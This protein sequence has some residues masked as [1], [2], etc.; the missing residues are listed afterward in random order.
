M[1]QWS[2]SN[3]KLVT[4]RESISQK[5]IT[6]LD[7]LQ[8]TSTP[9]NSKEEI[10]CLLLRRLRRRINRPFS[11]PLQI[12]MSQTL[13]TRVISRAINLRRQKKRSKQKRLQ[14]ILNNNAKTT[15]LQSPL[16]HL[17]TQTW[18]YSLLVGTFNN[19]IQ[20]ATNKLFQ[21]IK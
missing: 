19:L 12:S 4:I 14:R 1:N 15:T 9:S 13:N 2:S 10:Q 7:L 5:T 21:P 6:L 11:I 8:S 3:L 17:I 18:K 16:I 20:M